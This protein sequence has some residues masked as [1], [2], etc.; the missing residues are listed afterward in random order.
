ME[1]I[2]LEDKHLIIREAFRHY[3]DFYDYWKRVG[4][5]VIEYKGLTISFQDLKKVL[6][7]VDLS[8]RKAQAFVLNVLE[9]KKQKEVAE[10]M[11]ITTVSVGQYVNAACRQFSD[12]YWTEQEKKIN[13]QS[14]ERGNLVRM[15]LVCGEKPRIDKP[16]RPWGTPAH[17]VCEDHHDDEACHICNE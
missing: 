7:E 13:D 16:K 9:D 11:G 6:S 10:I 12:L 4:H 8:D 3:L 1:P 2:S 14:F 5:H 15:C 17:S